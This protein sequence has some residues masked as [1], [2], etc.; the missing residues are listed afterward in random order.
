MKSVWNVCTKLNQ[1]IETFHVYQVKF[2]IRHGEDDVDPFAEDV[3][4][5]PFGICAEQTSHAENYVSF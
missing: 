4:R 2:A 3:R 1:I 5:Y